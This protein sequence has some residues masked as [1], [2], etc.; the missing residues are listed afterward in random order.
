MLRKIKQIKRKKRPKSS[1]RKR[2]KAL[3]YKNSIKEVRMALEDLRKGKFIIVS[4]DKNR[5]NEG[6]L[7]IPADKVTPEHITFMVNHGTGIICCSIEEK[8]AKELQ[9][10]LMVPNED[11]S[12]KHSCAFTV[13]T[14]YKIGTSTGVSSYD[15]Y[16]TIN[17][18]NPSSKA[19]FTD[20]ARPGHV[21]PLIAREGGLLERQGHT[22]ASM[23]LAK[24]CGSSPSGCLCELVNKN[25]T[26][27]RY[28]DLLQFSKKYN[29]RIITIKQII[30]YKKHTNELSSFITRTSTNKYESYT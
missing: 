18:L 6:D 8:R 7:I 19:N 9:L 22:E 10:P 14:D 1:F 20:F 30:L 15:R 23:E 13:S 4:D 11:N 25:G 12:E 5:E 24:L 28:V 27:A 2:Q 21:F 29:I 3:E 26:M 16:L 17:N